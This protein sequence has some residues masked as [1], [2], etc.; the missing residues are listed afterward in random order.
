MDR[1]S[2]LP[3]AGSQWFWSG[4]N[5]SGT[6]ELIFPV[7]RTLKRKFTQKKYDTCATQRCVRA[8]FAH[9]SEHSSLSGRA[10]WLVGIPA[11][12]PFGQIG[13]VVCVA[14]SD[15]S[16]I[17]WPRESREQRVVSAQI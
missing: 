4:W 16:A 3:G 8:N 11:N 17:E 9:V 6:G 7:E 5:S 12:L 1:Q 2:C 13:R 14:R 15:P 10:T